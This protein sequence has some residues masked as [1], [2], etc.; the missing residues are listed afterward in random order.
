MAGTVA[1]TVEDYLKTPYE[2]EPEYVH[3]ELIERPM[4]NKI[5][6]KLTGLL[7]RRLPEAIGLY[8][9]FRMRLAYDVF[10]I[11]DLALFVDEPDEIPKSPPLATI[12]IMSPDDRFPEV[13][14]KCEEYRKWGVP[15]IWVIEPRSRKF[16]VYTAGLSERDR[17]ELPDFGFDITAESLFA[18]VFTGQ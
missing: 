10:R 11:P 4:P 17:F 14:Q 13:I 9:E 3:G 7:A 15:N 2:W 6:A 1:I 8:V 18:K 12:E 5:H 16:F